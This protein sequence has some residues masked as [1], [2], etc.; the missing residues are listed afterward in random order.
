MLQIGR[1]SLL[2]CL[3]TALSTAA[4]AEPSALPPTDE[5]T[6]PSGELA[7][8]RDRYHRMTV[9]VSVAGEGPYR[10]LIDTGAQASVITQRVRDEV[11][12]VFEG[13]A[14]LVAMGSTAMVDLFT[15]NRLTFAGYE[16]NNLSAA[17]LQSRNVGADGILG[18]NALQDKRVLIDFREDRMELVDIDDA[19]SSSGYEIVV[20]AKPRFGQ[21]VIT[22]ARIDGVRTAVVIDTGAQGSYGNEALRKRM[23]MRQGYQ[24]LSTDV[25]GVETLNDIALARTMRLGRIK[26][27]SVPIGFAP[28]P[29]FKTLDLEDQPALI[30]GIRNLRMF[31]R[32]AI[33]FAKR[34][35]MFDLP[36]RKPRKPR[37]FTPAAYEPET[38]NGFNYSRSGW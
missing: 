22:S 34:R 3:C 18:L 25:N 13:K 6:P 14:H 5:Y 35:V 10:F 36:P 11:S 1:N 29:V 9:P 24:L 20:R 26:I 28:S 17:L 30:L 16:H 7:F 31:D 32:V 4:L 15:L 21:M 38:A 23:R 37:E 19:F 12:P 2:A 27:N 33:D 8:D